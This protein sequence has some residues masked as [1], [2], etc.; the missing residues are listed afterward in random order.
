MEWRRITAVT[1]S[2]GIAAVA[3]AVLQPGRSAWPADPGRLGDWS[4][5]AQASGPQTVLVVAL[6]VLGW[7]LLGWFT[8]AG[9]AL[10]LSRL[11]GRVGG[12][13]RGLCPALGAR[14]LAGILGGA[15]AGVLAAP[16]AASAASGP[17][18]WPSLDWAPATAA[19]ASTPAPV[20]VRADP[21]P[22]PL[23]PLVTVRPADTLWRIAAEHLPPGASDA[24]VA[25]AWP[26]WYAANRAVIGA[27]PDLLHPG[28]RLRAP[29]GTATPAATPAAVKETP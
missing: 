20:P 22:R 9:T 24:A 18:T 15:A 27:D 16:A 19:P 5:W 2:V 10:A 21:P 13:A 12:L 26:R 25:A 4:T 7:L 23:P 3:L 1:A 29:A 6:S 17:A 14:V 8:L 28:E 11:P